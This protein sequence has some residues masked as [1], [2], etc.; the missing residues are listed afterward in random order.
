MQAACACL[1]LSLHPPATTP[2]APDDGKGGARGPGKAGK[3]G[4]PATPVRS[5]GG[6]E[7]RSKWE[8]ERERERA[9]SGEADAP[10]A[11]T[12][13]QSAADPFLQLRGRFLGQRTRPRRRRR[14]QGKRWGMM[15]WRASRQPLRRNSLTGRSAGAQKEGHGDERERN[16]KGRHTDGTALTSMGMQEY[17][18]WGAVV[19]RGRR[20]GK[21]GTTDRGGR[22]REVW[23]ERGGGREG[24]VIR[25]LAAP[26]YIHDILPFRPSTT[27]VIVLACVVARPA[28][29]RACPPCSSALA[30]RPAHPGS[31]MDDWLHHP[32]AP[33][34]AHPPPIA[35]GRP[36][37]RTAWLACW[38][39]A[40]RLALLS[41]EAGPGTGARGRQA[42]RRGRA[43]PPKLFRPRPR[44][45]LRLRPPP[46]PPCPLSRCA[47]G[48]TLLL[49]LCA[50][51]VRGTYVCSRFV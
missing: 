29:P 21:R 23:C 40:E 17:M 16:K 24:D 2:H 13:R 9:G 32:T 47:C 36:R 1:S 18:W 15:L 30:S 51:C 3:E 48:Y 27:M 42:G 5:R 37:E 26:I 33:L 6:R 20:E 39:V 22:T 46:F 50:L 19:R 35:A 8:R 25:G 12:T 10:G 11:R 34:R 49:W 28:V 4:Q 45:R 38:R 43:G 31:G 7:G 44:L 14:A 41:P